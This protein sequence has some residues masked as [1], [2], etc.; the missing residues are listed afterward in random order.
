MMKNPASEM[1]LQSFEERGRSSE[2][3]AGGGGG[4]RVFKCI[5]LV[6]GIFKCAKQVRVAESF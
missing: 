1:E 2:S 6:L 3:V 5:E 4:S